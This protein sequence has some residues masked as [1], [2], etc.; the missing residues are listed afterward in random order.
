VNEDRGCEWS[1]DGHSCSITSFIY[2]FVYLFVY[3]YFIYLFIYFL[4]RCSVVLSKIV[5]RVVQRM[6]AFQG[7]IATT[8]TLLVIMQG[9][10]FDWC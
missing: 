9:S 5:L 7:M 10:L 3:Y 8:Q 1:V 2:L 6:G 4:W